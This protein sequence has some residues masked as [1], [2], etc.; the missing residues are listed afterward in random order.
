MKISI[1]NVNN[2][3]ELVDYFKK[4]SNVLVDTS[5]IN[6]IKIFIRKPAPQYFQV[7]IG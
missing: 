5:D 3:N 7:T 6:N 1:H 4:F 2:L